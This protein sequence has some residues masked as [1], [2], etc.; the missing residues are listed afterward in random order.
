MPG[1]FV[2]FFPGVNLFFES[3]KSLAKVQIAIAETEQNAIDYWSKSLRN[4]QSLAWQTIKAFTPSTMPLSDK[5]VSTSMEHMFDETHSPMSPILDYSMELLE[6]MKKH[7]KGDLAF[8]DFLNT[9]PPPQKFETSFDNTR[10]LLDL[11]SLKLID[12]STTN[13]HGIENYTVVFAP[14]AGHH[15][16]IA[17]RVALYL[18]DNGLTRIAIVEQKC[19]EEIPLFVDDKRHHEGFDS[20]VKQYR[21]VLEYLYR[22]TDKPSHLV[23]ICQPGPI[24]AAT[25]ILNPH[26]AKTFG[27]AGSPMDT[28]GE[29]GVLTDFSRKMGSEYIDF[30][31]AM[32]GR[33][34]GKE[35][36]GHGRRYYDGSAQVLGFYL[37]G[38]PQH[39][40]NFTKLLK[41]LR[42][43]NNESAER[44]M[45]FYEWYNAVH[46]FPEGFIKDTYRKIFVNNELARG[47]LTVDG[48]KV[49]FD[50]FPE[51][52]PIWAIGGSED[53]IAPP[54]QATG[55]LS[56]INSVPLEN[57]LSI[58]CNGGHMGLFRSR[59]ILTNYYSKVVRFLLSHSDF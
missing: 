8:W 32:F 21:E 42:E 38:F 41:D 22:L 47:T 55:H 51:N 7:S 1:S 3:M 31:L 54:L 58:I 49:S 12:I 48:N 17:E 16:N 13:G 4:Q 39:F 50:A 25:V 43:G 30:I 5:S 18:R 53:E 46:H 19:C 52:V 29:P 36:P 23:A 2:S 9:P 20:Q 45:K 10:V 27:S 28:E 14:R 24:L 56:K 40:N 26:L 37:F 11:P 34:V 33:T 35:H 15:S 6:E 57:K 44:Q 59:T